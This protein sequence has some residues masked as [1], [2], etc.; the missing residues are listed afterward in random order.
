VVEACSSRAVLQSHSSSSA[1][2]IGRVVN[3]PVPISLCA[4]RSVTVS[5]GAIVSHALISGSW[6]P[7][8][9]GWAATAAAFTRAGG[10]QNP[11]TIAPPAA[12]GRLRETR[13]FIWAG[14]ISVP[15]HWPLSV[16]VRGGLAPACL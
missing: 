11:N 3:T 10:S 5:S 13:P 7:R 4:T 12:Q 6:E 15:P 9:H 2:I 8:Y 1:I 16:L 14:G